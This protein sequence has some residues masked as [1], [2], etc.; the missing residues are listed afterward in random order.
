[1]ATHTAKIEGVKA[2]DLRTVTLAH[3]LQTAD[4]KRIGL[5][6][7][8]GP[9]E[10]GDKVKVTGDTASSLINAGYAAVDPEDAEAVR[11]ILHPETVEDDEPVKVAH[12]SAPRTQDS[13][14]S[15]GGSTGATPSQSGT[16]ST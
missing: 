8:D 7:D 4:M 11:A 13:Q 6:T 9:A 5:S 1:M 3:P 14:T 16:S 10:V 12:G 15:V 2:S